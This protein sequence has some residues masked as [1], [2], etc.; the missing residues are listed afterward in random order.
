MR[1]VLLAE[2]A[3]RRVGD[4]DRQGNQRGECRETERGEVQRDSLA[5]ARPRAAAAAA[6]RAGLV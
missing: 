6:E 3:Q 2:R 4:G 5:L 1:H